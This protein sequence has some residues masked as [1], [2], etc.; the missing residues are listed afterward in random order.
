M[1]A[2]DANMRINKRRN[3][4][5]VIYPELSYILTGVFF[6][7]HN[8]LGYYCKESQYCDAIEI[9]L[10]EKGIIHKREFSL[11]S[12]NNLIKDN[13]NRVDFLVDEKIIVEVKAKRIV[14]R[15][16]YN[17]TQRYLKVLNLKLGII[18][19]FHQRYLTPKRIINSNA[20]E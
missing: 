6:K 13:S 11:A 19:N 17:Q 20:K 15:E 4:D 8:E 3:L 12:S 7:V 14:G 1:N 16:E 10:K 5:K 18:V 2:N 9:L